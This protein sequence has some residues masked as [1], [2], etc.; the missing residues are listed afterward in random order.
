MHLIIRRPTDYL[1]PHERLVEILYGLVIALTITSAIR[2]ITG[3][4]ALDIELMV[5][6]SLGAGLSWGIIDAMLYILVVMFQKHRYTR[7]AGKISSAKD[8]ADALATIQEDLED[9]LVG[10]LDAED[11]KSV[12]RL[13]LH[14][15]RRSSKANYI[16]QPKS[17]VIAR[18]DV[19]G[20]VQVF[21]A[22]LLATLVVVVPLWF[23]EPPHMA[24]LISNIVA[25]I[26][27]F[28][29][30]YIWARH[31]NIRKTLFGI[32]LVTL[33]VAIVGISLILGG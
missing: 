16:N 23:I 21:F 12:Y 20:A 27:L 24:V 32:V 14:A 7:I 9:S 17:I 4:V 15:Q 5:T 6:T 3:G 19:F 11:Q 10:T 29:V 1:Y 33:G 30:G 8:E 25:F 22:M 31:T 13:V 28:V 18:E 2:V 26:A